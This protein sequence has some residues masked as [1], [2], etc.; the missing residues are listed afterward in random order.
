[1]TPIQLLIYI[2]LADK[3]AHGHVNVILQKLFK[4]N[5]LEQNHKALINALPT[6]IENLYAFKQTIKLKT[7]N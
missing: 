6:V 2:A 1:M 7:K 4:K 5:A 3:I